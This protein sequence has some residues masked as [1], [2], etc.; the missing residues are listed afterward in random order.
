MVI[1]ETLEECFIELGK[2]F[3][4]SQLE[5]FKTKSE[6]EL[7]I[8][9]FGIGLWMRNNWGLWA[10][11]QLAKYFKGM[12]IFHANDMSGIILTS[13]HRHLKGEEVRLGKQIKFYQEYWKRGSTES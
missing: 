11:S 1:P 2:I 7:A 12:G 4:K 10:G 13:F 9:H 8:Y 3:N 5:E 6:D